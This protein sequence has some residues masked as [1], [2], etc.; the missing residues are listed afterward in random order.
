MIK[1]TK[2]EV[3]NILRGLTDEILVKLVEDKLSHYNSKNLIWEGSLK[4]MEDCVKQNFDVEKFK[5]IR[6]DLLEHSNK[7]DAVTRW[8]YN[9][10]EGSSLW[11]TYKDGQLQWNKFHQSKMPFPM[12]E[13]QKNDLLNFVSDYIKDCYSK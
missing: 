5:H 4:W 11:F 2:Y 10:M 9:M 12:V 1:F 6:N 3:E 8:A 7:E 13:E